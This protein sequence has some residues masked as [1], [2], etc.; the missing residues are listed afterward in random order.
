M[1]DPSSATLQAR[2]ADLDAKLSKEMAKP[3]PDSL[4]VQSLKKEKLRIKDKI[5]H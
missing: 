3:N 5:A 1:S 2:H 4:T